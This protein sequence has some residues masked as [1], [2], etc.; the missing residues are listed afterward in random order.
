[1]NDG[2]KS[3]QSYLF[4]SDSPNKFSEIFKDFF[5]HEICDFMQW[6]EHEKNPNL[7]SKSG[8]F[9]LLFLLVF[10]SV[11]QVVFLE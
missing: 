8:L 9:L 4:L 7:P 11:F 10:V 1:M 6:K 5:M 2:G 3:I